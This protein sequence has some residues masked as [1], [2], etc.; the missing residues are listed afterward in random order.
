MKKDLLKKFM[1]N[2][3]PYGEC[4]SI[5]RFLEE[6]EYELDKIDIFED[7][8]KSELISISQKEKNRVFKLIEPK[9]N[10]FVVFKRVLAAASVLLFIA[11]SFY[12]FRENEKNKETVAQVWISI[13]NTKGI[14]QCYVLPDSSRVNL[15]PGSHISYR[16]DFAKNREVIQ[17]EGDVTYSVFPN[18]KSPFRVVNQ[19]VQ[20]RAI[21]TMFRISAYDEDHLMVKLLEGKIVVEDYNEKYPE[22]VILKEPATLLI[23]IANFSHKLVR[24]RGISTKQTRFRKGAEI[25]P[26][27]SSI[28]W[29]NRLVEFKGVSNADLFSIMEHLFAVHIAVE[30][31]EIERGNFTGKLYQDDNLEDLLEIFCQINGCRYTIQDNIIK[32]K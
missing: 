2:Q 4:E 28:A 3:C 14:N 12:F 25:L 27:N 23:N 21:G 9:R 31:P 6:N 10:K 5:A 20:T 15:N 29:S 8:Q 11:F 7:L 1:S 32:I 26:P 17:K 24:D 19:G 22:K 30:N 18:E 16:A 13:V